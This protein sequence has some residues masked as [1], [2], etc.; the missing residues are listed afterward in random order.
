M[1]DST[2]ADVE[3]GH[4]K[5][6]R[7]ASFVA[8]KRGLL[9]KQTSVAEVRQTQQRGDELATFTVAIASCVVVIG[10]LA[11]QLLLD[12][13]DS[14]A[15]ACVVSTFIS[16]A[17]LVFAVSEESPA[18][19]AA[20]SSPPP[21]MHINLEWE[22]Q[23]KLEQFTPT[24][25]G[26]EHPLVYLSLTFGMAIWVGLV[27]LFWPWQRA[28]R[29]IGLEWLRHDPASQTFTEHMRL[30]DKH[31]LY[32][33]WR[34]T[35]ERARIL[36]VHIQMQRMR[37]NSPRITCVPRIIDE[38]WPSSAPQ[39]VQA[40]PRAQPK[41][42]S[43]GGY[44]RLLEENAD[45]G[46]STFD[47]QHDADQIEIERRQR[48]LQQSVAE[49]MGDLTAEFEKER[50]V[51]AT[52]VGLRGKL[53]HTRDVVEELQ[54][55]LAAADHRSSCH[56]G[57]SRP[58]PD[59]PSSHPSS[60]SRRRRPTSPKRC[61]QSSVALTSSP[62]E[63]AR[64]PG[65]IRGRLLEFR[66]AQA[67]LKQATQAAQLTADSYVELWNLMSEYAVLRRASFALMASERRS[68]IR[69]V[70]DSKGT[71]AVDATPSAQLSSFAVLWPKL[72]STVSNTINA[73]LAATLYFADVV[74][75][76]TVVISLMETGNLGYASIGIF[77]LLLQFVIVYLRVYHAL[78]KMYPGA[79]I[80]CRCLCTVRAPTAFLLSF[81][82]GVL[83]L[84]AM[85]L[86]EPFG[87]LSLLGSRG[88]LAEE[89]LAFIP[90]YTATRLIIESVFE[91][92]FQCLLQSVI[93]VVVMKH[94][95][96]GVASQSEIALFEFA[97]VLPRSILISVLCM[98]KTWIK[99]VFEA[100]KA[101]MTVLYKG[102]LLYEVGGGL[103]LDALTRSTIT[104][105]VCDRPL[106][107]EEVKPL[108]TALANNESLIYLD[109][110]RS[111]LRWEAG[112][113]GSELLE[114][115]ADESAMLEPLCELSL[116]P[117]GFCV[118]VKEL[119]ALH[120]ALS[121][122]DLHDTAISSDTAALQASLRARLKAAG[123]FTTQGPRVDE[124]SFMADLTRSSEL[125]AAELDDPSQGAPSVH[126]SATARE[127][128][129]LIR[130][131]Y[132]GDMPSMEQSAVR[133][134]WEEAVIRAVVE[135][136]M[137]H[138]L[139]HMLLSTEMLRK[140]GFTAG[141]LLALPEYATPVALVRQG[142]YSASE[143][144]AGKCTALELR[145]AYT[146]EQLR[147]LRRNPSVRV[148][149]RFHAEELFNA[150]DLAGAGFSAQDLR[151]AGFNAAELR[152]TRRFSGEK[153]RQGGFSAKSLLLAGL[154]DDEVLHAG[155][156]AKE[157]LSAGL[158]LQQLR[159]AGY[160]GRD[161]FG[162]GISITEL[163][164]A[165]FTAAEMRRSQFGPAELLKPP[166]RGV[167]YTLVELR[168]GGY[169]PGELLRTGQT[170]KELLHHAGYTTKNMIDDGVSTEA[171]KQHCT[172]MDLAAAGVSIEELM[173]LGY[174][175]AAIQ[176]AEHT[177][178][179]TRSDA[180][181]AAQ[182]VE[183]NENVRKQR[184]R[185]SYL[186]ELKLIGG[187][188]MA[189]VNALAASTGAAVTAKAT[190]K[191]SSFFSAAEL[192]GANFS[193]NELY[194]VSLDE[195][196]S[197][198]I[199]RARVKDVGLLPRFREC[200]AEGV[201]MDELL[202]APF[203]ENEKKRLARVGFSASQLREAGFSVH[204]L[205]HAG[206]ELKSLRAAR[207]PVDELKAAG[208]GARA[209][210]AVGYTARRLKGEFSLPE[211]LAVGF[212]EADLNQAGFESGSAMI[213]AMRWR[214]RLL[215]IRKRQDQQSLVD[216]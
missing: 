15:L 189:E 110:G 51:L 216:G 168:A 213:Y 119:R 136:E 111:E 94:V 106:V 3:E 91:S 190:G 27:V 100:R 166:W 87:M 69:H 114:L 177:A 137:P 206:V 26:R 133:H 196:A 85:M 198:E 170:V 88:L 214:R 102:Y 105:Y 72:V 79:L 67:S 86:L 126:T 44:Q 173:A 65:S 112:A 76:V 99:V 183:P 182:M 192:R 48:D 13:L 142:R 203:T 14:G 70:A 62:A 49:V 169:T 40:M 162:C 156:V 212:T 36:E 152:D 74:T 211:L 209:L 80:R 47:A 103:P 160:S 101:G 9:R 18:E 21:P 116:R 37:L 25:L 195:L 186:S 158:T 179:R 60:P 45:L 207:F 210:K 20:F 32:S 185:A 31:G 161:L 92:L 208:F 113:E 56:P 159:H 144:R 130:R 140:V 90:A 138:S 154:R 55:K 24:E 89:L 43:R 68:S 128:I 39:E 77:L 104:R 33:V 95:Q 35:V 129:E 141:E 84:D 197:V 63:H 135:G 82:F 121:C 134:Q 199:T 157:L 71:A 66:D 29:S 11:L 153:L 23:W 34:Y 148:A 205:K 73:L 155:F 123:L 41:Q 107:P 180:L 187:G 50:E 145:K 122:R 108:I 201:P 165:G 124:L 98:L 147:Q 215:A 10:D 64:S 146:S 117:N 30:L 167:A 28:D 127:A 184:S 96:A 120:T 6:R 115:I 131:A 200:R 19:A 61:A 118:P 164:V 17:A 81:P 97:F 191:S 202:A 4:S 57:E 42:V 139:M 176:A 178:T 46:M 78:T 38:L 193:A 204:D 52:L 59:S 16:L 75:D 151:L 172:A 143:L 171:L 174:S 132:A 22:W 8:E 83:L 194:R 53:N 58:T 54:I 109:L 1:A 188:S 5:S 2:M 125:R 12:G 175:K 93:F 150:D 149:R 181:S 163:K 7:R